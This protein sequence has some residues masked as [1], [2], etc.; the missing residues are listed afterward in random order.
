M[1]FEDERARLIEHLR[2]EIRDERVLAAMA[3][4][5]CTGVI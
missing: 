5:L 3:L 2:T 1:D 4:A